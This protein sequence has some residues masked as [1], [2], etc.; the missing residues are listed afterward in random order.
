M[1]SVNSGGSAHSHLPRCLY[2]DFKVF[3]KRRMVAGGWLRKKAG[4]TGGSMFNK[5]AWQRRWLSIDTE[6]TGAENYELEYY[7][8]PDDKAPRQ[9]FPLEA[10]SLVM[11]GGTSFH[12]QLA[13]G[14]LLQL[15]ADNI[16][17]R[18][19]WYETLERVITV[20]TFRAQA[21]HERKAGIGYYD[22]DG[23]LG[24]GGGDDGYG[25]GGY[26]GYGPAGA[27]G[28]H[29]GGAAGGRGGRSP[30]AQQAQAQAAARKNP[31]KVRQRAN[32]KVR[33]DLDINEIPP[34]STKRRQFEEMFV[35][36]VARALGCQSDIVEVISVKP[37]PNSEW[38]VEVEFDIYIPPP[39]R[40]EEHQFDEDDDLGEEAEAELEERQREREDLQRALL[41]R[42]HA[43]VLSVTSPLYHGFITCKLD[44]SFAAHMVEHDD[45]DEDE[46]LFSAEPAVLAAMNKYSETTLPHD[47]IDA[48]HF[49]IVVAYEG[50][51]YPFFVPNPTM[52][53]RGRCA[54]W[55]FEIKQTLGI[56]GTMQE[57]WVEPRALVPRDMP[58]SMS[59][60][61]PFRPSVRFDGHV[62][63]PA[64][65][66]TPGVTYDVECDDL[67]SEVLDN[68]T[69][70][71]KD[72]IQE[73]FNRYDINHDGTVSKKE[74]EELVRE[75]T[76]ARRKAVEDKFQEALAED[77]DLSSDERSSLEESRRQHLQQIN[78][79]QTKLLRMFDCAD[80][81]GDGLLSLTEFQLAEAWFLRC[82]LNPEKSHLF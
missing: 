30:Q 69:E 23:G 46:E 60:P 79:A 73:V 63:I 61:I 20:A 48:S 8:Y 28:E 67:R 7:H 34:S 21:L 80:L 64:A 13:D 74:M 2:S 1:S 68:L 55:P 36:D 29:G 59:Q 53:R 71:E 58:L 50:V 72:S 31:F 75:R 16:E 54:V 24:G 39:S 4:L 52:L 78:E 11:A 6:I 43:M 22:Q 9:K 5:G 81:N 32:P 65:K 76:R 82:T 49:E 37:A 25:D 40:D 3:D 77:P 66:L 18:D 56:M 14:T 17:K 41:Q 62:C 38:L 47:Y 26:G 57:Q 44:S 10:A 12:V 33:L 15:K 35:A 42:L 19:L 45:G 51:E 27:G 70:E